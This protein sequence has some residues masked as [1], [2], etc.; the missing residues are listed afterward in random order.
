M[1]CQKVAEVAVHKQQYMPYDR[2]LRIAVLGR[3][4]H[5]VNAQLCHVAKLRV[6]LPISH[7]V[8]EFYSQCLLVCIICIA[9]SR[10]HT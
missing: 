1:T 5:K 7:N 2:C 9:S 8:H 4:A 10:Y 3:S 6:K